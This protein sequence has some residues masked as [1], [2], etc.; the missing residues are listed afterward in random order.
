MF[1]ANHEYFVKSSYAII[2]KDTMILTRTFD[3]IR[4][5]YGRPIRKGAMISWNE[6]KKFY[7][8]ITGSMLL[9]LIFSVSALMEDNPLGN[10]ALIF[11]SFSGLFFFCLTIFF[12]ILYGYKHRHKIDPGAEEPIDL[13]KA[14]L[15]GIIAMILAPI[16]R[17][18]LSYFE[19]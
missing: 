8:M 5:I 16:V 14:Y 12:A 4:R 13:S 7:W 18:L 1:E 11:W 9:L 19:N 6:A 2:R 17:L 3:F 15:G 10:E